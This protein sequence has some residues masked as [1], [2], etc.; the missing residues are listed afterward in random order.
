[1]L[2]IHL[3]RGGRLTTMAGLLALLYLVAVPFAS[4]QVQAAS[5]PTSLAHQI[6]WQHPFHINLGRSG[7]GSS[8]TGD[9]VST[10]QAS[11]N[12]NFPGGCYNGVA[13]NVVVGGR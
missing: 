4:Q 3:G 7:V 11:P 10:T 9:V 1:M 5:S 8:R 12:A 13:Y 6:D 2:I